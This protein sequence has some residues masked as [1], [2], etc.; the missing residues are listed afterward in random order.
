M[1]RL[2]LS[3]LVSEGLF[4]FF[5][6]F[7]LIT[8][9]VIGLVG[10]VCNVLNILVFTRQGF[11]DTVNITLT[12]LAVSDLGA[13]ITIQIN[14]IMLNPWFLYADVPFDPVDVL[15]M[16]SMYPHNYF[17]RV[18]GFI[19][20]FASFERCVCVVVPLKLK[21]LITKRVTVTVIT[22]IYIATL[23][24]VFPVYYTTYLDWTYSPATNKSYLAANFRPTRNEVFA[25]S[26]FIT[27]LFVPNFTFVVIITC[28]S[29]IGVK[30]RRT[31]QWKQT[32]NKSGVTGKEMK[33]VLML[34]TVSLTFIVCLIPESALL[35]ASSLIRNLS[36]RGKYFD[37]SMCCYCVVLFMENVCNTVNT[38]VYLKMSGRYRKTL[39]ELLLAWGIRTKKLG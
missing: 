8:G 31:A 20:A 7:N 14:N 15:V 13:L 25:V 9:E 33:V 37:V 19:T 24:V 28:T 34:T 3:G 2:T 12:A 16:V 39:M 10:I 27:D 29:I 21:L 35:C 18:S 32:M 23:P 38:L 5:L 11:K 1:L 36:L 26:Y 22:V 17:I 30:L 6:A 4:H